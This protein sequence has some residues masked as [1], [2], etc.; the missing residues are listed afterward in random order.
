M[1]DT[2]I[3]PK[4]YI[5]CQ[6]DLTD[7][8]YVV[9][10]IRDKINDTTTKISITDYINNNQIREDI[11]NNNKHLVCENNHILIKY[12]SD[13]KK[14]HFKHKDDHISFESQW[15]L[16]WKNQFDKD[17]REVLLLKKDNMIKN[18]YADV[19]VHNKSLEFQ[20]SEYPIEEINE[21]TS[22]HK[23]A[24]YELNWII[25]C[26]HNTLELIKCRT[27]LYLIVFYNNYNTWKY[28]NFKDISF[29]YLEYDNK[30]FKI[31]P[32]RVKSNM[33]YITDYKT[34]E[35]FIESLK[36]NTLVWIN[37][38]IPQSRLYLLQRGAGSGKTFESIQLINTE[39]KFLEKNCFIYLTKMK[40]A[41][42]VIKKELE[43]QL[44]DNRISNIK[45]YE[46]KDPIE[47]CGNQYKFTYKNKNDESCS[48]I[49]GTIDAFMYQLGNK[50]HTG[51]DFF[52]GLIK[53]VC[54]GDADHVREIKYANGLIKLCQ[55]SL[56]II[57]E[58]QDLSPD[59]I[60][61]IAQIMGQTHIDTYVIGDKL[62][63]IW[64]EN[65]VFT[66]LE[67]NDFPDPIQ[68]NR[69]TGLN[70]VRRFHN[71]LFMDYV[72]TLIPFDNFN[73]PKISGIC[74][75]HC[76]YKHNADDKP[77]II[78]ETPNIYN[79]QSENNI[80]KINEVLDTIVNY[81]N[82]EIE[83]N[84]YLPKN[85]M[86]IFPVLS[87]NELANRLECKLQEF[88]IN[89]F[90]DQSYLDN[91]ALKDKDYWSNH[92][93]KNNYY[94]FVYFHK[95]SEGKS[96][97]LNESENATRILS[98]HSSKGSGCEVV[99]LLNIS[100]RVLRFYS[101]KTLSLQ[102]ESLLHVAVTR[103]KLKLYIGLPN[104][105][106]EIWN[107]FNKI[108]DIDLN[109]NYEP[110]IDLV[111]CSISLNRLNQYNL[112]N[113]YEEMSNIFSIHE[114]KLKKFDVKNK[115]L[116]KK[117]IE[118]GHHVIRNVVFKYYFLKHIY[119]NET[120]IDTRDQFN[121]IIKK[122][123]KLNVKLYLSNKYYIE[124]D[125]FKHDISVEKLDT[126]EV[127]KKTI[128]SIPILYF[129]T[130]KHSKYYEYK[131]YILKIIKTIQAK[132]SD[133]IHRKKMPNLCP[134][135]CIILWHL[136]EIKK[137][138]VFSDISIIDVYNIMYYY[139]ES[140]VSTERHTVYNCD[141]DNL[142]NDKNK[143]INRN[144]EMYK[145]IVN[146]YKHLE[147]IKDIYDSYSKWQKKKYPNEVFKYNILHV[148]KI[149]GCI[150]NN[151]KVHDNF[152]LIA[153]SNNYV[154]NFTLKPQLNMINYSEMY[155][156]ILNQDYIIMNGVG[157]NK[158]RYQNK[159]IINFIITLDDFDPFVLRPYDI[160]KENIDKYNNIFK[161]SLLDNLS[162]SNKII[163]QYYKHNILYKPSDSPNGLIYVRD[164]LSDMLSS[165]KCKIPQFIIEFIDH[166][167][168]D[169]SK[170]KDTIDYYKN[171]LTGNEPEDIINF[172]NEFNEIILKYI[173]KNMIFIKNND[174]EIN[175]IVF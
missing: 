8:A 69:L 36:T 170:N 145:N 164:K 37:Y 51:N 67:I 107:R 32:K 82:I 14:S 144:N 101:D 78:F 81:M 118:W 42:D 71:N 152:W 113:K 22:D 165:T 45:D 108:T 148:V 53:S 95:S 146:H 76:K 133:S 87:K 160:I 112:K 12:K 154:I 43:D 15:H 46:Q 19:I 23:I 124:L 54:D 62:Q 47:V 48:V 130:H 153:N 138:G 119:D 151:F 167:L 168:D 166:I 140:Y 157:E 132:I 50:N 85:F 103:Q 29:I 13:K 33:I 147:K 21:R 171:I 104:D 99:F 158:N 44:K 20:H 6:R 92:Y 61:A 24:G 17:K 57:D 56:I 114:K 106:G 123:Y 59:Y 75:I 115:D 89:K 136:I 129:E 102:Y 120:H 172:N 175:N 16:D 98:I 40:S 93:N 109:D 52:Q 141:C 97:N 169:I 128:N 9:N 26:T 10:N 137:N 41:R 174:D 96:I 126:G 117:Q 70:I 134:I 127:I 27:D 4:Q 149:N 49:I 3:R 72:N 11:I 18:R 111:K 39:D 163:R 131:K 63:S 90:K 5:K 64:G 80:Q 1:Q 35:D 68:M 156:E 161:E 31:S 91:I 121:T 34:K 7:F 86:F 74:D 143:K 58:A 94:Q 139:D 2:D 28:K 142:F 25:D 88:W 125:K 100:E 173:D 150:D 84:N 155:I 66:Y 73:L 116:S 105:G 110:Q 38:E 135:E 55:R 65:N 122:I 162:S 77:Y 159:Q 30:I 79:N 60:R 83:K